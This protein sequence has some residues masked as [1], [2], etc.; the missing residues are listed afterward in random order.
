MN[1]PLVVSAFGGLVLVMWLAVWSVVGSA[2]RSPELLTGEL[3]QTMSPDAKVAFVWGIGNLVEFERSQ[4]ATPQPAGSKSFIPFLVKGLGG[5]SIN[6]VVR[7]IDAWYEGHPDQVKRPVVDAL[8]QPVV[9]PTLKA[10][11]GEKVK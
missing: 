2:E 10:E 3:W 9:L 8:F 11:K 7:Q 4:A 6:E 5:K 1:R